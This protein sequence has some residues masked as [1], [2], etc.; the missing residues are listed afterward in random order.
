MAQA[1]FAVPELT[2]YA[3]IPPVPPGA[4]SHSTGPFVAKPDHQEPL[5]CP[6]EL[7]DGWEA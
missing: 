2:Q 3:E 4:M 1:T 7:V 6:G 5:G